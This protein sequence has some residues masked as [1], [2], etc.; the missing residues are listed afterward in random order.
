MSKKTKLTFS[1][2]EDEFF[3]I[4]NKYIRKRKITALENESDSD[5]R[6]KQK[7]VDKMN[8]A[9]DTIQKFQKDENSNEKSDENQIYMET[10][11]EQ[12]NNIFSDNE[13]SQKFENASFEENFTNF[14]SKKT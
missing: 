4:S 6:H 11:Y 5:S 10:E 14:Y 3:E 1:S 7:M 12:L 9:T 2:S 13:L 8:H